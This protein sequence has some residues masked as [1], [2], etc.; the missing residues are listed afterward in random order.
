MTGTLSPLSSQVASPGPPRARGILV[1][2]ARVPLASLLPGCPGTWCTGSPAST[3]S[4]RVA[5]RTVI[6]A[7]GWRGGDRLTFTAEAGVVVT[8]ATRPAW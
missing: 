8:A 7:L 1:P 5:D 6:A 2:A 3:R 4:G